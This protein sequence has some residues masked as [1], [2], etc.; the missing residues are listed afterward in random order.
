MQSPLSPM[1][2]SQACDGCRRRKVRCD[3][4][5]PCRRCRLG[6]ATCTYEDHVKRKTPGRRRTIAP[7]P[8]PSPLGLQSSPSQHGSA[9]VV[10]VSDHR[11]DHAPSP[12][13]PTFLAS[14]QDSG[15]QRPP[16]TARP[17]GHSIGTAAVAAAAPTG[18]SS[19]KP[20][21][22]IS[23]LLLRLHVKLFVSKV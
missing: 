20:K 22:R 8:A 5:M 23:S 6:H 15:L 7:L 12:T 11:S 10:V 18:F 9:S 1:S 4:E 16:P 3:M 17:R 14:A 13:F 2:Q 21:N 19:I